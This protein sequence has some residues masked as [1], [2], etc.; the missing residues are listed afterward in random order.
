MNKL[1]QSLANSESLSGGLLFGELKGW[2]VG[3][4]NSGVSFNAVELDVAVR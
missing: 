1:V 2:L 3:L 4:G